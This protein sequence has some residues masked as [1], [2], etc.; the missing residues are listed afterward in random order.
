MT[1]ISHEDQEICFAGLAE[2]GLNVHA[3]KAFGC[4]KMGMS[5]DESAM[6]APTYVVLLYHTHMHGP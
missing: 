6:F 3:Q 4:R 5:G 1:L 2:V